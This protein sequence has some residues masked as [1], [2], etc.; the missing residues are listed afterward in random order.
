VQG[1]ELVWR[2]EV[3]VP[4]G[5]WTVESKGLDVKVRPSLQFSLFRVDWTRLSSSCSTL[6]TAI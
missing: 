4:P 3:Q 1:E 2:G 5:E 6:S